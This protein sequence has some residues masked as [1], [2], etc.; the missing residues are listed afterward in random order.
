MSGE[1]LKRN[2]FKQPVVK[3]AKGLLGTNICLNLKN[4]KVIRHTI[5]ET[6][7]YDGEKDLACHASKGR[8]PRTEVMYSDGGLL[9]IY[10]CYGMHWMLNVVAEEKGSPSAVLLRGTSEI[11]GPGRLTKKLGIKGH[12]NNRVA[13]RK[14]GLWFETGTGIRSE[15][16]SRPRIGV[17]YAGRYWATKPYRFWFSNPKSGA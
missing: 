15:I 6:E 2:F 13:N 14:N 17:D 5:T 1:I 3:V 8:T 11:N 10:L 9:Y 16:F 4:G 12:L 7:A